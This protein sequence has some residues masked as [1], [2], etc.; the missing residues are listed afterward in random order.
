MKRIVTIVIILFCYYPTCFSQEPKWTFEECVEYALEHNLDIRSKRIE[1]KGAKLNVKTSQQSRLPNL[2]FGTTQ[3]FQFGRALTKENTYED[4]NQANTGITFESEVPLFAGFQIKNQ[5]EIDKLNLDISLSS[6]EKAEKDVTLQIA[7]QFLQI[8]LEKEL[9]E[10][11]RKQIEL[12]KEQLVNTENLANL[13]R[14]P[15]SYIYDVKAQLAS[16]EYT[17]IQ[18]SV[19]EKKSL[20][21]LSQLLDLR[22]FQEFDIKVPLLNDIESS[23]LL[24]PSV[25][26]IYSSALAFFPEI[27]IANQALEAGKKQLLL[28][29]SAYYP[30]IAMYAN[31]NNGY[32]HIYKAE[33]RRLKDQLKENE[34]IGVG[35][36]L[37]MPIF[38][39]FATKNKVSLSKLVIEEQTLQLENTEKEL[40]KEIQLAYLD[41]VTAIERWKAGEKNTEALSIAFHHLEQRYNAGKATVYEFLEGRTKLTKAQIEQSQ[42]RY[43]LIFRLKILDFYRGYEITL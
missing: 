43:E 35:L 10:I 9:G 13:G 28:S 12:I 38:N 40:Y 5:I 19:N 23:L 32:Y 41:A 31:Y 24:L 29:K 27:K 2:G 25:D 1:I 39:R 33:N 20:F 34:R 8:L 21:Y 15:Q 18:S 30:S 22:D 36:S 26:S 37:S 17:L 11:N 7:L 6:L 4:N 42:I 16:D 14:I 3:N